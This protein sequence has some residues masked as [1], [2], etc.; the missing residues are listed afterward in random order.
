MRLLLTLHLF[1]T[2]TIAAWAGDTFTPVH[3]TSLRL[4]AVPLVAN[5]PY[6]CIW[7]PY[8]NLYEGATT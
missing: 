7:S 1:A 4:P 3:T 5:D 6:F 8:D 2:A